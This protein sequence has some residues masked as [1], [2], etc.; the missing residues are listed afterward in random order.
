MLPEFLATAV[1]E[2]C[3]IS[4]TFRPRITLVKGAESYKMGD[5]LRTQLSVF[6]CLTSYHLSPAET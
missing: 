1:A 6:A 4:Q 2:T 3:D 5:L